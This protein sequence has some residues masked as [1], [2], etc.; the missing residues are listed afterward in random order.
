MPPLVSS[1][2]MDESWRAVGASS[3]AAALRMQKQCGKDQEELTGFV[4]AFISDLSPAAVGLALF[5]HLVVAQ[6]FRRSGAKFRKIKPGRI[7]RTW[8]DNFAFINN[9]KAAGY[10]CSHF[11]VPTHLASEPAVLQYVIDALTEENDA[12]PVPPPTRSS[13]R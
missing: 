8:K 3:P 1:T 2:L 4:L 7:E 9:L 10:T 5:V 11:S 6:S 12:D 13:G